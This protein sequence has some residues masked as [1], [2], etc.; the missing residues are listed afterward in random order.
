MLQ[1]D[2][3]DGTRNHQPEIYYNP[4]Y[5]PELDLT[6]FDPN[7]LS[8]TGNVTK[9]DFMTFFKKNTITIDAV[10]KKRSEKY[11]YVPHGKIKTLETPTLEEFLDLIYSAKQ[12]YC[13]CTGTAHL[14]AA[15]KKPATIL[16]GKD[17]PK[18]YFYSDI[19]EYIQVP[20]YFINKIKRQFNKQ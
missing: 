19:C 13:V 6:I 4:T 9:E 10:M 8:L 12:L 5:K 16:Y 2:L 14:A 18:A 3:D 15:L 20:N 17:H 7:F 11:V 1:F